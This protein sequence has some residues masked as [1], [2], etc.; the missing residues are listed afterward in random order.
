MG[1]RRRDEA[2]TERNLIE[3]TPGSSVKDKLKR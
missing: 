2:I 1:K 3:G